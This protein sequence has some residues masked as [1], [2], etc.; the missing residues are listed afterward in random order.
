MKMS[1]EWREQE[2]KVYKF[3]REHPVH[4]YKTETVANYLNMTPKEVKDA[5]EHLLVL[6]I[7]EV[8]YQYSKSEYDTL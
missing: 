6:E 2:K 5:M 8:K 4:A 1:D 7:I 3:F